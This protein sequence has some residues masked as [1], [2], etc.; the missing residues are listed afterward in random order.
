MDETEQAKARAGDI[1]KAFYK[2][3]E[4]NHYMVGFVYR[5]TLEELEIAKQILISG[6][7]SNDEREKVYEIAI[8]LIE[9]EI[10]GLH[11]ISKR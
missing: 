1:A 4:A 2:I 11:F 3:A 9:Y 5:A 8:D 7:F 6:Q 10:K